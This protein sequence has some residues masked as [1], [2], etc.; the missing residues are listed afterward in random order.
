MYSTTQCWNVHCE[1]C[2]P[3]AL[4]A[5]LAVT[6]ENTGPYEPKGVSTV[7]ASCS[8][9]D[10][11]HGVFTVYSL[12]VN[13]SLLHLLPLYG[14]QTLTR[15]ERGRKKGKS[16]ASG[17]AILCFLRCHFI[18]QVTVVTSPI[19]WPLSEAEVGQSCHFTHRFAE[20]DAD[21][22]KGSRVAFTTRRVY[23]VTMEVVLQ[24]SASTSHCVQTSASHR[25]RWKAKT[26]AKKAHA[27][28]ARGRRRWDQKARLRRRRH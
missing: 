13:P 23:D 11:R 8:T 22:C 12:P 4:A 16:F 1:G 3:T 28:T 7:S 21:L 17:T 20:R 25:Q 5:S 26:S 9:P 10:T 6:R 14:S 27:V 15:R 24:H 19:K 18:L 2:H